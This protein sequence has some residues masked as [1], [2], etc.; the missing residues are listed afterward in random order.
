VYRV[1]GVG[2]FPHRLQ[3]GVGGFPSMLCLRCHQMVEVFLVKIFKVE[4]WL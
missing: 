2:G 1:I 3:I 4:R